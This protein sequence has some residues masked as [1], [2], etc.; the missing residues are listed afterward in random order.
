MFVYSP[1]LRMTLTE[2]DLDLLETDPYQFILKYPGH[3][4]LDMGKKEDG[5]Y[6]LEQVGVC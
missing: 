5:S 3:V 2:E 6:E 4:V 1:P